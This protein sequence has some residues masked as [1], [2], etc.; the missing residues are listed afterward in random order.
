MKYF[1]LGL[2]DDVTGTYDQTKTTIQGR[3]SQKVVNTFDCLGPPL[4]KF[5]DVFTD[6]AVA[7]LGPMCVTAEGKMFVLG[8]V[9]A[10][11]G[12]IL[13]YTF[14]LTTGAYSYVGRINYNLPNTAATT[15]T[16]RGI[17]AVTSGG[18]WKIFLLT[19]GSVLINGGLFMIN[20]LTAADFIPVGFP[21]IAMATGSDQKAVYFLQNPS[22]LGVSHTITAGAGLSVDETGTKVY[23]HNGIAATHQ[24]HNW[25]YSG[26]PD[27]PGTTVTITIAS[28]G[29]VSHAGHSFSAND[30]VVFST[31]GALPTG[32][33]AGTVYFVRNPVAGTSYEVSATSGGASINTTGTQSG[34]HTA[35]RAFGI[36]G[37]LTYVATGNLPALTG[38]LLLT[39]SEMI[40]TPSSGSNSGSL[41]VFFATN[42]LAYQGKISEL[43]SGVTTWPS[44]QSCNITG[45]GIDITAPSSLSVQFEQNTQRLLIQTNVTKIIVKPF[46]NSTISFVFGSLLNRYLEGTNP[47]TVSFGSI[48]IAN[49][50]I[51]NGWLFGTGTTVGQ[52]GVLVQDYYSD[53]NWDYSYIVSPVLTI[54]S[55]TL[56]M[57]GSIEALYEDTGTISF[58]YRTSGF[59]TITGGWTDIPTSADIGTYASGTEI[60]FK[61]LFD[62]ST[63]DVSTPAQLIDLILCAFPLAYNSDNWES[64]VDWSSTGSPTRVAFRLK[65]AYDSVVPTTLRF[66]ATDLSDATVVDHNITANAAQFEYSTNSGT[67]WNPLGTIPN[68]VGTLVRYSFSSPPGVEIRPGLRDA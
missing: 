52:R 5:I 10:G 65:K 6:T 55:A 50:E 15:H 2:L 31:T 17:E 8:A 56:K 62:I 13:H 32:L 46:Q 49:I 38:T 40:R 60:Q 16:V 45:T 59:G 36:T 26:T 64:S 11:V 24:F 48:N 42:T 25:D 66:I 21:T 12:S 28:P 68:T 51:R 57:I 54:N 41:C 35:R 9:T 47:T 58:Q 63:Q 18:T 1:E 14:N 61:F 4:T 29:V 27:V 37:S 7:P 23:V 3:I 20:G 22:A 53:S 39:D 44:L 34:T 19:T 30:Q 67:S 33:T 43:T